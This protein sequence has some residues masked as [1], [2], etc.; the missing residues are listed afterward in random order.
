MKDKNQETLQDALKRLSTY[1]PQE[2]LW[3]SLESQLNQEYGAE[4]NREQFLAAI[5]R[6]PAYRA[7]KKV[8]QRIERRLA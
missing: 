5:R 7:P 4:E 8:W 6:L 2:D 3:D 1:Q